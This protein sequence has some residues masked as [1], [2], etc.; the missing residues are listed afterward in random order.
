MRCAPRWLYVASWFLLAT[1]ASRADRQDVPAAE[2]PSEDAGDGARRGQALQSFKRGTLLFEQGQYE[3]AL[4][5]F[6]SSLA[7]YPTRSAMKNQALCL[8]RLGRPSDALDVLETLPVRFPNFSPE[9]RQAYD[10]KLAELSKRVGFIE[11][12]GVEVGFEI[13]I[14]ERVRG[15]TPLAHALRV[16]PGVHHVELRKAGAAPIVNS[17]E[18]RAGQTRV[19]EAEATTSAPAA[20][21]AQPP[22]PV[23]PPA[24][25]SNG[26]PPRQRR[27][28]LGVDASALLAA[29]AANAACD[30]GCE[31]GLAFGGRVM[32]AAGYPLGRTWNLIVQAGYL[33]LVQEVESRDVAA[34][35]RGAGD[36]TGLLDERLTLSG[37][38]VGVGL[39]HRLLPVLILRAGVGAL[40]LGAHARREADLSL[41]AAPERV[42]QTQ[43]VRGDFVYGSLG[44]LVDHAFGDRLRVGVG[45]DV[46]LAHALRRPNWNEDELFVSSAGLG[47]FR[48]EALSHE[49]LLL[50]SP[51]LLARYEF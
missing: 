10:A 1:S 22:R 28:W 33:R 20:E 41:D 44:A 21:P 5:A 30:G 3:A 26:S 43:R 9:E 35:I 14:G 16:S 8:E 25:P 51:G 40:M 36:V 46:S 45:V 6:E 48:S 2:G 15:T 47:R 31:A 27:F 50:V 11:L 13:R 24:D 38:A 18:V 37:V 17:L 7:L 42:E 23:T 32:L 19:L 34:Q 12:R 39:E 4:H 49:T 29:G